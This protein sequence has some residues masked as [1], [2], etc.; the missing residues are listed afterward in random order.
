MKA[1]KSRRVQESTTVD[2]RLDEKLASLIGGDSNSVFKALA[3]VAR[4]DD[5][6]ASCLDRVTEIKI[7][8]LARP[9]GAHT[10]VDGTIDPAGDAT[11]T[12]VT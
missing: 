10:P 9:R 4:L 1:L 12:R 11:P 2:S 7:K 3:V 6:T 8:S 5:E